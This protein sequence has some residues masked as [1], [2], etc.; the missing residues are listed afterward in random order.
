MKGD[1]I[2]NN[3]SSL[4]DYEVLVRLAFYLHSEKKDKDITI[5]ENEVDG[6]RLYLIQDAE[7]KDWKAAAEGLARMIEERNPNVIIGGQNDND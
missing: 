3:S 7:K 4:D 6:N 5:I 1:I 2:V